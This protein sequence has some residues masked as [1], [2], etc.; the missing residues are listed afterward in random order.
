VK[1]EIVESYDKLE[2]G[3]SYWLR[4][5][6]FGTFHVAECKE[7]TISGHWITADNNTHTF[8]KYDIFG[9]IPAPVIDTIY[10]CNRH[11]G[12][13]FASDCDVCQQFKVNQQ[14]AGQDSEN[15]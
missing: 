8:E 12:Y 14:P 13:G 7:K 6:A 5:K 10:L 3:K 1:Y 15:G 9:P 11:G 4:S 2:T